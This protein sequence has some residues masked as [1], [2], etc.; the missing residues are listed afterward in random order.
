[1]INQLIID[2]LSSLNYPVILQGS[3]AP[4]EEIPETFITFQTMASD[5]QE[6][7]DNEEALTA[8]EINITIYSQDPATLKELATSTRP[9][10]KAADFIPQGKGFDMISNEPGFLG[11]GANYYYLMKENIL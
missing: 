11:W 4:E 3:Y 7:F 10:L 2:A 5:T 8:Y 6:S 9:L 1:M